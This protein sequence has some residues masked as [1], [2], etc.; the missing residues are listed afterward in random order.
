MKKDKASTQELEGHGTDYEDKEGQL[1][2]W[3]GEGQAM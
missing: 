3:E 2:R 1:C